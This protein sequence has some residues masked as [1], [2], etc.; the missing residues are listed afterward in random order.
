MSDTELNQ[1]IRIEGAEEGARKLSALAGAADRLSA[2]FGALGSWGGMLTGL[3]G[4][5]QVGSAIQD[6]DRLYQAV[7]RVRAMTGMAAENAHAMFDMFELSGI[8]QEAAETTILSL[9]RLSARLAGVGAQSQSLTGIMTRLGVSVKA[10][11]E[12]KLYQMADAAKAGK[13]HIHDLIKAFNIPRTQASQMMEMLSG[14]AERLRQIKADTLGGADLIDNAALAAHK[15]MLQIRRELADAWGGFIGTLYKSLMP[16][17]TVLLNEITAGFKTIE[18][19]AERVGRLLADNMEIVVGL[20]KTYLALMLAA[21]AANAFAPG[22]AMGI[23]GRGKQVFGAANSWMAGRAATAGGMDYFAAKAANPGLGMFSS[24]GGPMIRIFSTV[25]GRFGVIGVVIGVLA[26][27]FE[28]LRRNVFGIRDAF[29]STFSA[30]FTSL[31]NTVM[32]VIGILG[33]LFDAIKPV[34]LILGG[35]L[36]VALIIVAKAV[37]VVAWVI[38][39]VVIGLVALINGLLWAINQ[40]PGVAIDYISLDGAKKTKAP[41]AGPDP[42]G[43]NAQVYQDFR[44]STFDI[45]NNF[46]EGVDAGRIA[47]AFGDELAAL[48]ERRLDSGLRPLY[49]YR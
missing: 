21:K 2:G 37:E 6:T 28:L 46:P 8:G 15:R 27:A 20:A 25:I 26:A 43:K 22:P 44:G 31:K 32:L 29:A 24:V 39:K 11:P 41:G 35:A 12:E 3:A 16:A 47:V 19:V 4:L 49:S 17:A 23:L 14:G 36:L 10:G 40:I 1:R 42:E 38:E 30:I 33:K 18:P 7:G 9:S 48:G 13:L 45:S 5:W 34:L